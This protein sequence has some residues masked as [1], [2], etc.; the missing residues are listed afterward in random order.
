M[1][2]LGFSNISPLFS[3]SKATELDGNCAPPADGNFV[4]CSSNYN[5][6]FLEEGGQAVSKNTVFALF[7]CADRD[8]SILID[9]VGLS[10]H[11]SKGCANRLCR[12]ES[13]TDLN[14]LSSAQELKISACLNDFNHSTHP[15]NEH[16]TCYTST[17]L[18]AMV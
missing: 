7:I 14:R 10:R 18:L 11:V 17:N 5:D 16:R 13:E 8:K 2:S 12:L 3:P 1:H 4:D 15:I 6:L 9:V